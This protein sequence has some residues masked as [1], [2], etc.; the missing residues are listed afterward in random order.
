MIAAQCSSMH[1]SAAI[2]QRSV[3]SQI[4]LARDVVLLD[5]Y[6]MVDEAIEQ[7]STNKSGAALAADEALTL[8]ST[9]IP[10]RLR[11]RLRVHCAQHDLS[12]AQFLRSAIERALASEVER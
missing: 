11:R 8:I 1:C 4:L 9:R 5:R 7:S 12:A 2:R 6:H 3:C 10:G